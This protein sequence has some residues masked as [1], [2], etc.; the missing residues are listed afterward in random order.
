ML[1]TTRNYFDEFFRELESQPRSLQNTTAWHH[2]KLEVLELPEGYKVI[3]DVPGV[4]KK[5]INIDVENNLLRI[6]GE[7][8]QETKHD[9]ANT[10]VTERMYGSFSRGISL[11]ENCDIQ[12][13]VAKHENGV[14]TLSF[15]K[16]YPKTEAKKIT[17]Q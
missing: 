15:N 3:A 4:D 6:S 8:K 5:D 9:D 7:R 1:L 12:T 16:K 10:L 13:G 14:L 11:P 17:I 2:L